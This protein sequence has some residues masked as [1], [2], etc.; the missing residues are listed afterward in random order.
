MPDPKV[1][2][3][4]SDAGIEGVI[5]P[6][7]VRRPFP[8]T[9]NVGIEFVPPNE[10]MFPLTVARVNATEPGPDAVPSPVRAVM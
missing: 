6:A 3:V 4:I 10:P 7:A 5:A 1:P 8:F 9:V 2:E